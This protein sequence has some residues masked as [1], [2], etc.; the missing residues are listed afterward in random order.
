MGSALDRLKKSVSMKPRRKSVELPD[1]SEFEFWAPPITLAQRDKAK[2]LAPGDD[3]MAYALQLLVMVATDES[4][5]KLFQPGE[6]VELK[7]A[8][9]SDL[10]E[11]IVLLL[12]VEP[13]QEEEEP[14]DMKSTSK[15][16]KE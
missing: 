16:A 7:Q 2:K 9:P 5:Q 14:T 12:L 1:G 10:V 3:T 6:I 4:G 11:S 15:A 13:E 8:L